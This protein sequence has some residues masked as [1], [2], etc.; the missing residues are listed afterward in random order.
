MSTGRQGE[1][2][3]GEGGGGPGRGGGGMHIGSEIIFAFTDPVLF[4]G[5]R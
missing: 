2:E 1:G 3:G 5:N 4:W